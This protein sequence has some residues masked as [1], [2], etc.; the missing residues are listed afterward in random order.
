MVSTT[1]RKTGIKTPIERLY[2]LP[3]APSVIVGTRSEAISYRV[4]CLAT[5]KHDLRILNDAEMF[6]KLVRVHGPLRLRLVLGL[7][8]REMARALVPHLHHLVSK[9]ALIGWERRES[10]GL[11]DKYMI[12]R[13]ARI[14]Y[15]DLIDTLQCSDGWRAVV[16]RRRTVYWRV[17]LKEPK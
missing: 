5:S 11:I 15:W 6:D 12:G 17:T 3:E 16:D 10:K 4:G 1:V 8:R 14:A 7:S 13:V 2:S 9:Q